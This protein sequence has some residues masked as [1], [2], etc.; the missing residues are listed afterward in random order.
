MV[1]VE[2]KKLIKNKRARLWI[3]HLSKTYK[4]ERKKR[5]TRQG[6]RKRT[7]S[8]LKNARIPTATDLFNRM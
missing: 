6:E 1:T 2:Q 8:S 5:F 7:I 3:T 4:R